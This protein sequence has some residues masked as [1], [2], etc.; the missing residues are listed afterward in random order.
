MFGYGDV[1]QEI[2]EKYLV[3]SPSAI[4]EFRKSPKAYH[5]KYILGN[6]EESDAMRQGTLIHKAILEPNVFKNEYCKISTELQSYQNK[7]LQEMCRENG[8]KVG[9]TKADLTERIRELNPDF[10]TLEDEMEKQIGLG[11]KVLPENT[12]T[13]I[14]AIQA[15]LQERNISKYVIDNGEK[16]IKGWFMHETGVVISF[17]A[18]AMFKNIKEG[19][20]CVMDLKTSP[21]IDTNHVRRW[22]CAEGRHIQIAA[23]VDAFSKIEKRP[24]ENYS[25]FLFVRSIAPYDVAEYLVDSAMLD[26][27]R[28][29]IT[30]YIKEM[31][32]C[33]KDN[34]WPGEQKDIETT[35]LSDWD[36][37]NLKLDEQHII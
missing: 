1:P 11:K 30:Y 6:R 13:M 24:F 36:Y 21:K 10:W 37:Q 22:H 19:Q 4:I 3:T 14:D 31:Q 32:K 7:D 18:D 9:G 35:S 8:L 16:E 25:Y 27:G 23:Y 26:A 34:K 15:N 33:I 12:W 20:G 17:R 28:S 2:R 5:W 29:E